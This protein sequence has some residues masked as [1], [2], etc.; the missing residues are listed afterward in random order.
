MMAVAIMQIKG[1][2]LWIQPN[3]Q[4]RKIMQGERR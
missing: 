4:N 1:L 2:K 3:F